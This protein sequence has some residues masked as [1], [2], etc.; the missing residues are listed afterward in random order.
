MRLIGSS[1]IVAEIPAPTVVEKSN[2]PATS[3]AIAVGGDIRT[4]S[5][6][7]FSRAKNPLSLPKN[8]GIEVRLFVGICTIARALDWAEHVIEGKNTRAAINPPANR[9]TL[10]LILVLITEIQSVRIGA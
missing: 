1:R 9:N 6:S 8:S 5:T 2:S 10:I 4:R 7:T 3:A